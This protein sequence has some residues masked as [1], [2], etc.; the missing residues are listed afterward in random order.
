MADA[1]SEHPATTPATFAAP[2]SA[3]TAAPVSTPQRDTKR[4]F[5]IG[6]VVWCKLKGYPAWPA[7]VCHRL[8][9]IDCK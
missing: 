5:R 6:D 9:N 8:L 2:V 7:L 1:A 3:V 4:N